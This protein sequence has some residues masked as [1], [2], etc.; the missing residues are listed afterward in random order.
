MSGIWFIENVDLFQIFCPH[1]FSEY[2]ERHTF[3]AFRKNDFVYLE[4][5]TSDKIYLIASGRIK[6][7]YYTEDGE[8]VVKGILTK[9]EI[10]GETAL[11]G[12]LK[13]NE[14]AQALE[15]NTSLCPLTVEAMY[16]LMLMN[17]S[18]SL[19]IYKWIGWRLNKVERKLDMLVFK[20]VRTRFI[21]F[22]KELSTQY[23]ERKGEHIFI[24]H[25]YSQKNMADLIGTSRQSINTV[26]NELEKKNILSF[27]RGRIILKKPL[28]LS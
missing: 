18:F 19:K 24:K 6:V 17:K 28:E 16:D 5:D 14:F 1:K 11:L 2:A 8:E 7:G 3:R 22:V 20:D 26:I 15:N 10:F 12:E 21:E 23:G 13:R 4:G 25:F 27:S 9:G